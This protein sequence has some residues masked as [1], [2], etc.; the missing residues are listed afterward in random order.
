[1]TLTSAA[2]VLFLV[3]DPLGNVP[4]FLSALRHV[5]PERQAKVICRELLIAL[6][7]MVIFLFLGQY[8]L[9]VL[10]VTQPALTAAGGVVLFLI[11][12]RMVFP[13]DETPLEE[14]VTSEPLIVPLAIPYVAGPSV[15]AT[16]LIFMS[17]NPEQWVTWLSALLIAWAAAGVILLFSPAVR[18]LLGE[19]ILQATERLMGMVLIV[20]AIQMLLTGLTEALRA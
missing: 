11:A 9:N 15:L 13:S 18:R 3:L 10:H 4:F 8:I 16:E 7:V 14:T 19:R 5:A 1:M 6:A 17:R 2:V 20:I 12:I